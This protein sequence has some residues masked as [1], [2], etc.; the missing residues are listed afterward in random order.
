M[1][2]QPQLTQIQDTVY[3]GDGQPL[4][5]YAIIQWQ[6]FLSSD[7]SLVAA[8]SKNV[9]IFRGVLGVSLVP[10]TTAATG[11]YYLVRY[12][13]NSGRIQSTEYWG[14]KPSTTPL[15]IRDVRLVGPPTGGQPVNSPVTAPVEVTIPDVAGLSDELAARPRKAL[16]YEPSRALATNSSGDIIAVLGEPTDC[17]RVDGTSGACG[18]G[19]GGNVPGFVDQETPAGL[20]NGT[21]TVFTLANAPAPPESLQVVN[22][23]LL[24]KREID[25][26]LTAN[27][28]TFFTSSVPQ[29]GDLLSA[30]YR[31]AGSGGQTGGAAASGALTGFYPAPTLASGAVSNQHIAGNA[32]IAESK[33]ALNFAT[34]SS[35]NDPTVDQ[36]SA[37]A[38]TTG[39]PSNTN[40]F[41]TD[42]DPR[43]TNA[44][45]PTGHS[46][47][48]ASH[49]DT[50]P[51]TVSRGDLIVGLGTS[52]TLWSRLPLGAPNRCLTSN[53]FDAV[54]NA[55]LYTGFPNGSVP[56]VDSQGNLTYN[57]TR[58]FWDNSLRRLAVGSNAPTATLSVHDASASS[59]VTTVAIRAGEG[60]SNTALQRWQDFASNDVARVESDGTLMAAAVRATSTNVRP[61]WHE[62][63]TAVD[64]SSAANG[65]MWLNTT[66]QSRRSIEGGQKH[67]TPQVICSA[68][69]SP[70]SAATMGSVG[71][72]HIPGSLIRP[73]DRFEVKFDLTHEG[74]TTSYSYAVY[75][76]NTVITTRSAAGSEGVSAGTIS[77]M[78]H[79][80]SMNWNWQS[81]GVAS[82]I[83]ASAGS[84]ALPAGSIDVD[85]KAMMS[86]TTSETVTLRNLTVVRYPSVSNIQ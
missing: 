1:S 74:D 54:W 24:L 33:L 78:T 76:G 30:S 86:T 34:H 35:A 9:R 82:S 47:L 8:Y 5:G 59:G 31:V 36:K 80:A 65:S 10:T 32:G 70:S 22:N 26:S 46:F 7:S 18:T 17:V 58:L 40:R 28:I 84:G 55:C 21:N 73:G 77:V 27:T 63:G 53:G 75:W 2:A 61:A 13:N 68:A 66:E 62:S 50:N 71:I 52:P 42:Q 25:Y 43:L 39:A 67:T 57:N 83:L 11:A 49:F 44:R 85:V 12:V 23:G 37:L 79:S 14:V 56:F 64:P 72:C 41:V 45:T 16:G 3:R 60:Q 48:S 20:V 51:G 29:P 6:S 15:K 81:W 4:D 38:G 19:G 69:G